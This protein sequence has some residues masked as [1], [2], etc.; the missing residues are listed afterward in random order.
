[1]AI[2]KAINTALEGAP[3][4]YYHSVY[5]ACR[6]YHHNGCQKTIEINKSCFTQ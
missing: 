2:S 6:D 3:G 4:G 5:N 1:M